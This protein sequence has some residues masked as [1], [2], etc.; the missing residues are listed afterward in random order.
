M[1]HARGANGK[2]TSLSVSH[3]IDPW[4]FALCKYWSVS[5]ADDYARHG[6]HGEFRWISVFR[7]ECRAEDN[8][9]I[10]ANDSRIVWKLDLDI[11][12]Q[13]FPGRNAAARSTRR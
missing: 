7:N 10:R 2:R 8:V 6:S 5:R 12:C 1:K 13:W 11:S 4:G 9:G 3:C